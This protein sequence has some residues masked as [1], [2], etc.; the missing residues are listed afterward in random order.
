MTPSQLRSRGVL[1]IGR[2]L[3]FVY[4]RTR[5]GL[6]LITRM[7]DRQLD[8]YGLDLA[9]RRIDLGFTIDET[10][11]GLGINEKTLRQQLAADGWIQQSRAIPGVRRGAGLRFDARARRPRFGGKSC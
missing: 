10:A 8:R 9:I 7:E 3:G 11:W 1:E 2:V 6:V 5:A 4:A